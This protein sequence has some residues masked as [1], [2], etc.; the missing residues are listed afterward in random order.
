[1]R[2]RFSVISTVLDRSGSGDIGINT[3]L[4][5]IFYLRVALLA[6]LGESVEHVG[7]HVADLAELGGAESAGRAGG[8]S[9]ADAAGLDRGQ[10]VVGDAVLV[11]GDAGALERFV[12]ILAGHAERRQVD[13]REVR[14]GAARDDVAPRSFSVAAST[15]AFSMI[16]AA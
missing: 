13:Q 8:R 10:R 16:A 9:D 12:G 4:H 7:D 11:A 3:L 15:L 1:M 5:S 6:I 2:V 14:V